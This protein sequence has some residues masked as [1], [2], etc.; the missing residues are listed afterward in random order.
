M[1]NQQSPNLR[2]I[3]ITVSHYCEKVRWALDWLNIAYVEES[4]APPFHRFYT[5]RY[6]GTTVPVLITENKTFTDS[7]DILHYLDSIAPA[8][9]QLYPIEPELRREVE[10]LEELFDTKLGVAT[11][12][13]AYFYRLQQPRVIS[14]VWQIR[15]PWLE[16]VGCAIAFPVMIRLLKQKYNLTA[17]QASISLQTIRDIFEV[18]NQRLESGQQYLVGNSLS[19]ADI[20]FAALA[21]PVLSPKHHPIYQSQRQKPP[22]EMLT[23]IKELRKTL[24]GA[25][26]MRLYQE[27]RI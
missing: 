13:W 25:F 3:T 27:L 16:K 7:T 2:L 6:G 22:Q 10:E 4:H 1:N 17:E 12:R 20:T 9:K 19:V 23:I 18:V 14:Q 8:G 21:A 24:A 11:R 15:V 5:S 26:V